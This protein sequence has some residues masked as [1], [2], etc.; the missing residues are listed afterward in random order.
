VKDAIGG[1]SLLYMVVFFTSI[2]ILFFVGIIA[3]SKAYRVKNRI[4]EVIEKHEKYDSVVA[5]EL[6]NDLYKYGYITATEQQ[7]IDKCKDGANSLSVQAGAGHLY[8]VE[9]TKGNTYKI[10]T[11]IHF[12]FPIIGDRLTFSVKGEKKTLGKDYNY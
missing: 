6:T 3:Y 4:I 7:L 11:Y 2:I 9:E 1:S 10:V 5:N 12:D 8:C